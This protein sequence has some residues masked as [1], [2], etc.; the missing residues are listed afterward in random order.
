MYIFIYIYMQTTMD[1]IIIDNIPKNKYLI[2]AY[3]SG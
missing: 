3:V 2:N 1:V